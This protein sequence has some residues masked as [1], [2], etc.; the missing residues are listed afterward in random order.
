MK[1]KVLY[2]IPI[3]S[4]LCRILVVPVGKTGMILYAMFKEENPVTRRRTEQ[5]AADM[6]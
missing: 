5:T 1:S 6:Q 2:A 3:T 4:A